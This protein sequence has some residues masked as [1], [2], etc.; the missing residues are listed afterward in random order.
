M[1]Y[2]YGVR[3]MKHTLT[4]YNEKTTLTTAP[5]KDITGPSSVAAMVAVP[6][7][8]ATT[9]SFPE[10]STTFTAADSPGIAAFNTGTAAASL[11]LYDAVGN[12]GGQDQLQTCD[13]QNAPLFTVK[14]N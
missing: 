3:S 6:E 8:A 7:N 4:S 1:W 9:L 14:I 10:I 11:T 2:G 13:A 5:T 12:Q